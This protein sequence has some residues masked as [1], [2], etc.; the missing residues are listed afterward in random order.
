[1]LFSAPLEVA[2]TKA[3]TFGAERDERLGEVRAHEPVGAGDERRCGRRRPAPNSP[4]SS[5]SAS[6]VHWVSVGNSLTGAESL[7]RAG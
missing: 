6:S 1:M 7:A 4:R 5:S 2:R 3:W